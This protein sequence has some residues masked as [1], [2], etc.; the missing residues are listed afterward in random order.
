MSMIERV[1]KARRFLTEELLRPAY[2]FLICL[3]GGSALHAL[4]GKGWAGPLIA[5]VSFMWAIDLASTRAAAK[6]RVDTAMQIVDGLT[7]GND[8]TITVDITHNVRDA[9]LNEQVTG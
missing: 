8:S 3:A 6:A 4:Q 5:G 2:P 9:A 7:S 1:K